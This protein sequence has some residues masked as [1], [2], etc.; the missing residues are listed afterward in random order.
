MAEMS[1]GGLG[2]DWIQTIA[3]FIE[4]GLGPDC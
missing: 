1:I 4:F 3:H 2:L